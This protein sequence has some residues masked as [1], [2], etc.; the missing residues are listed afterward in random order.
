MRCIQHGREI[1]PGTASLYFPPY[2]TSRP[3]TEYW[4]YLTDTLGVISSRGLKKGTREQ[5]EIL[6]QLADHWA[7]FNKMDG[8]FSSSLSR[9]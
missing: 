5:V 3:V 2:L 8:T 9:K 1:I 7:T 4:L 6:N